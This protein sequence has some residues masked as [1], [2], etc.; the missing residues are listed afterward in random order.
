L[1]WGITVFA[2]TLRLSVNNVNELLLICSQDNHK[3]RWIGKEDMEMALAIKP[4]PK[5]NVKASAEF[6]DKVAQDLREP[7][8]M[9]PTPKLLLAQRKIEEYMC[10]RQE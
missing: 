8:K 2:L 4:T 1:W 3:G 6:L 10:G 7:A 9:V 5:L